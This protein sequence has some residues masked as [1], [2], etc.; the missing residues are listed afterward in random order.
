M[1]QALGGS[2][3][4]LLGPAFLPGVGTRSY[5]RINLSEDDG[6]YYVEALVPGIDPAAL[7]LNVMQRNL[8]L[9][10]ERTE[11]EDREYTWHRQER[12]AGKFMR[13]IDLAA[14]IDTRRVAAECKN[15]VLFIT[16]PKMES[17]RPKR[18]SLKAS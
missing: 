13:T 1:D 8:S 7:T 2:G 11:P 4:G 3:L 12:G 9:A 10:G 5:P 17:E 15:G 18:I 16:L 6:H 14:N